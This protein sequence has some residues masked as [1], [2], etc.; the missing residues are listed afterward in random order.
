MKVIF[1]IIPLLFL[2][3]AQAM[4]LTRLVKTASNNAV[5]NRAFCTH[6]FKNF[7]QQ[8][9]NALLAS[10]ET[11]IE[12]KKI[13]NDLHECDKRQAKHLFLRQKDNYLQEIHKEISEIKNPELKDAI[14]YGAGSL[15]GL[16]LIIPSIIFNIECMDGLNVPLLVQFALLAPMF[17]GTTLPA[18]FVG[19]GCGAQ[20]LESISLAKK[21]SEINGHIRDRLFEKQKAVQELSEIFES[22]KIN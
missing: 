18:L 19:G 4:Q 21:Q 3:P 17:A 20:A 16:S 11:R 9:L 15:A 6:S 10:S 7:S 1:N 13:F 12:F 8:H 2:V 22:K 5:Y 14:K